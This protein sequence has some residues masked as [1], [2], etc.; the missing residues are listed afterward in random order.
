[1]RLLNYFCKFILTI[2][3]TSV[4]LGFELLDV[5]YRLRGFEGKSLFSILLRP[6]W[7]IMPAVSSPHNTL[8]QLGVCEKSLYS[9][10]EDRSKDICSEMNVAESIMVSEI[11]QTLKDY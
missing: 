8:G 1:M 2:F 9:Y 6:S 5:L 4:L 10:E 7:L 3:S 11:S